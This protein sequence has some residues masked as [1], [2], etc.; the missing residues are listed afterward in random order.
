MRYERWPPKIQNNQNFDS[1]IIQ[2]DHIFWKVLIFTKDVDRKLNGFPFHVVTKRFL[3]GLSDFHKNDMKRTK[4]HRAPRSL[5]ENV[6][7]SIS[8]KAVVLKF[9]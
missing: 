2:L 9:L 3:E 5:P 8:F 1:Y 4:S 7:T 6:E